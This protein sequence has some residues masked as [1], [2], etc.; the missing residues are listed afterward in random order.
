MEK[1]YKGSCGCC[2][3]SKQ[4]LGQCTKCNKSFCLRCLYSYVDGNN[5]AITRNSP[6]L[7]LKCYRE[8]YAIV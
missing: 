6:D 3:E 1:M 2:V 5:R 7:C 8:V 4:E